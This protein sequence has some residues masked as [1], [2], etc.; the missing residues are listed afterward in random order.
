M[1]TYVQL[2][3][4]APPQIPS[5][6]PDFSFLQ[7]AAQVRSNLYEQGFSQV[8]GWYNSLL[9]SKPSNAGLQ[10]RQRS[11]ITDVENKLR[12]L[13]TVDLSL[14]QNVSIANTAFDNF[15]NDRELLYDVGLTKEAQNQYS[16][17]QSFLMSNDPKTR[18]MHSAISDEYVGLTIKELERANL[19]DGSIFKVRKR[20]YVPAVNLTEKFKDFLDFKKYSLVRETPDGKGYIVKQSNGEML[21]LPLYT[22]MNGLL[23]G[24]DRK[25]FDAWGEV[26]YNREMEGR[27]KNMGLTEQQAR[28]NIAENIFTENYAKIA[29]GISTLDAGIKQRE[30]ELGAYEKTYFPDGQIRMDETA[31]SQKW[32]QMAVAIESYKRQ[33]QELERQKLNYDTPANRDK[34]IKNLRDLGYNYYSQDILDRSLKGVARGIAGI[35]SA[36]EVSDDKAYW[37][38]VAHNDRQDALA[39]AVRVAQIREGDGS[40]GGGSFTINPET[41]EITFTGGGG[42][43]SSKDK[44]TGSKMTEAEKKLQEANRPQFEGL[45]SLPA[46][47]NPA[48]RVYIARQRAQDQSVSTALSFVDGVLNSDIGSF[49]GNLLSGLRDKYKAGQFWGVKAIEYTDGTTNAS[50]T[51]FQQSMTAFKQKYGAEFDEWVKTKENSTGNTY[52]QI[53]SFLLQKAEGAYENLPADKKAQFAESR[54]AYEQN[55]QLERQIDNDAREVGTAIL[56]TVVNPEEQQVLITEEKSNTGAN[57]KRLKTKAELQDEYEQVTTRRNAIEFKPVYGRDDMGVR[58]ITEYKVEDPAAFQALTEEANKLKKY[59]DGYDKT[60]GKLND[61]ITR[62]MPTLFSTQSDKALSQYNM[63]SYQMKSDVTGELA[64]QAIPMVLSDQNLRDLEGNVDKKPERATIDYTQY[65]P[66]K[67]KVNTVIRTLAGIAKSAN[68]GNTTLTYMQS[69]PTYRPIKGEAPAKAYNVKFDYNAVIDNLRSTY[70]DDA[71]ALA[72]ID[73]ITKY[74]LTVRTSMPVPGDLNEYEPVERFYQSKKHY[75]TPEWLSKD[76]TYEIKPNYDGSGYTVYNINY[77]VFDKE[78]NRVDGPKMDDIN[79]GYN[80]SFQQI[81]RQLNGYLFQVI[82]QSKKT[83]DQANKNGQKSNPNIYMS[84]DKALQLLFP[85]N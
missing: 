22:L 36:Q 57:F 2:N 19:G 81:Q 29:T 75:K 6:D 55:S 67:D 8:K 44:A 3:P 13:A 53:Y 54:I 77:K 17:G 39:N 28:D 56:Q 1:A 68:I 69:D 9:A 78:G 58:T 32:Q 40:G 79:I 51:Q 74:G 41:G 35:A 52:A 42:N 26:V 23:T 50:N 82:G 5:F 38:Q 66:K 64:E 30:K 76:F 83:Y 80:G 73:N 61:L 71:E 37:S 46:N 85:G 62:Q 48:E 60:V 12:N 14:D 65:G 18:A 34:E 24:D 43:N 11:Y 49:S 10:E 21:E 45:Q 4:I 7:K 33:M 27:M 59:I 25:Y 70:K 63:F 47:V 31:V 72:I 15:K 20:D 16:K 84:R